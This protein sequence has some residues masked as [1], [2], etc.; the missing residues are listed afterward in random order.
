VCSYIWD[1]RFPG[2]TAFE[3]D[4]NPINGKEC[5]RRIYSNC[6]SNHSIVNHRA[7]IQVKGD[8]IVSITLDVIR[9]V[10]PLTNTLLSSFAAFHLAKE[11]KF[12]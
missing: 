4:F 7:H 2:P 12:L 8:L 5:V 9:I 1:F 3:S 10:M 11:T 6:Q